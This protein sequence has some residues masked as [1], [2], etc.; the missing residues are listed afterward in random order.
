[1]KINLNVCLPEG[2]VPGYIP[3]EYE[4]DQEDE[5]VQDFW[6]PEG[7]IAM[8][9]AWEWTCSRCNHTVRLRYAASRCPLAACPHCGWSDTRQLMHELSKGNVETISVI[10]ATYK[11]RHSK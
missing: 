4:D 7:E 3:P 11:P 10:K 1:M 8:G 2:W 5:M 6:V 9:M